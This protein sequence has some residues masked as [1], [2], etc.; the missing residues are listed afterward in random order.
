MQLPQFPLPLSAHLHVF[1]THALLIMHKL[2]PEPIAKMPSSG[3]I[4]SPVPETSI[5]YVLSI[6]SKHR[7]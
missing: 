3:S 2:P 6:T 5:K 1:L 7:F 4:T